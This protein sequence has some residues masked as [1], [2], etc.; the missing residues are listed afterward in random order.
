MNPELI[1]ENLVSEYNA[2]SILHLYII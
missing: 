1:F 2:K